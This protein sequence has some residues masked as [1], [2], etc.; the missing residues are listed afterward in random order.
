MSCAKCA[1]RE[2]AFSIYNNPIVLCGF[3]TAYR[4]TEKRK[5]STSGIVYFI[6]DESGRIKIG[7]T[8]NEET[9]KKRIELFQCGNAESL[10]VIGFFNSID[11]S[12]SERI[13]HIFFSK[14]HLLGEW[15][16]YYKLLRDGMGSVLDSLIDERVRV[17]EDIESI[18]NRLEVENDPS[19]N[20]YIEHQ[21]QFV[22]LK[23][24]ELL[25]SGEVGCS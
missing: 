15:F 18:E 9:L 25:K 8:K 20:F 22:A 24:K 5:D 16:D 14:Y 3:L 2:K 1:L 17:L 6:L 23:K 4:M 7:Y 21:V 11:A 13:L 10:N 19:Y 12:R